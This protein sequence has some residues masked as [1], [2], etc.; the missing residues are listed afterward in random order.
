ME[1]KCQPDTYK[2]YTYNII[3]AILR[4]GNLNLQPG[5][6]ETSARRNTS[7]RIIIARFQVS[8]CLFGPDDVVMRT[9]CKVNF[10]YVL[11]CFS[12]SRKNCIIFI[13]RMAICYVEQV[14]F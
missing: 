5:T 1:E 7:T 9:T 3:T 6:T 13:C 11:G 4:R 2:V 12:H 8:K 10:K 14:T